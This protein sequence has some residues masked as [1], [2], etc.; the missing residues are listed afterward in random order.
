MSADS[1]D[2]LSLKASPGLGAWLRERSVSLLVSA[3]QSGRLISIGAGADGKLRLGA[4]KFDRSMGLASDRSGVWVA[5]LNRIW[6]FAYLR[7]ETTSERPHD[8]VLAPQA[9]LVTGYVNAHDLAIGPEGRP[10]FAATMFNCIAT[11]TLEASLVPIWYPKFVT[12]RA[13]KDVCHLNGLALDQGRLKYATVFTQRQDDGAWR[14]SRAEGA[15]IDVNTGLAVAEGLDQPHS[16]RLYA[17][18]LWVH[19]SGKG[20]FGYLDGGRLVEVLRCPGYLRGL[21]F[22]RD[23]ACIGMSK[24]RDT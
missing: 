23:I 4:I 12:S 22:D 18:R 24:P 3:Y 5:T 14:E 16:P 21:V 8:V 7:D 13:P 9:A 6:R 10:V 1:S 17:G 11:T 2:K 19:E 20:A 15:A